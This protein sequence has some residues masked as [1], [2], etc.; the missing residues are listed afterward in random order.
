MDL[1]SPRRRAKTV[2]VSPSIPS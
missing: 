1:L 2:A